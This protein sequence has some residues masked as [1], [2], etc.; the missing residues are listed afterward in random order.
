MRTSPRLL[1]LAAAAAVLLAARTAPAAPPEPEYAARHILVAYAGA[2][3]S[4]ATRT[5][6]EAKALATQVAAEAQKP[7]ADFEALSH[8]HSDDKASDAQGGFL[9]IFEAGMMADAFLKGVQALKEGQISDAVESPFG[10]HVIQRLS[11]ADAKER[12]AKTVIVFLAVR[13]PWG[14]G[15]TKEQALADAG[16]VAAALKG[17]TAVHQ[18]PAELKAEPVGGGMPNQFHRSSSKMHAGYENLEKV[19]VALP[20]DGVSEPVEVKDSWWVVRRVPWFHVRA[21]HLIVQWKGSMRASMGVTRTKEQAKARA[22]EALAKVKADPSSWGKVVAEYSE[23][24]GAAQRA[25]YLGI[26][27]PGSWVPAFERAVLA[28]PP[29]GLSDVVETEFGW[30]VLLRHD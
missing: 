24:P 8:A 21:S 4:Q 30:H 2:E 17:G 15:R 11:L 29:G 12:V 27:E 1:P 14:G 23:E 6:A 28:L 7:G 5:K 26:G 3:R 13:V 22:Q 10:F 19:V 20:A 16:K 18:L 9:G 25:G